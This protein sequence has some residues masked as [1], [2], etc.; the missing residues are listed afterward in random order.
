MRTG[1]S[2]LPP[3]EA[4]EGD[5]LIVKVPITDREY[6]LL[7]YRLQDPD[8]TFTYSFADLNGNRVPDFYDADSDSLD[9]QPTSSYDPLTDTWE[10]TEDS[11]WDYFMSEFPVTEADG[12]ARGP[13]RGNG[14][15][16]WHIDERVIRDALDA[17]TS[18][19]NA[20]PLRKG[21]DLEEADGI[22]DLDS[23]TASR[24]LLGWDRDCFRGEGVMIGEV[25]YGTRF[26]ADTLPDS[27]SADG[28]VTGFSISEIDSVQ[29]GAEGCEIG[30]DCPLGGRFLY[31]QRLG[32]TLGFADSTLPP[33]ISLK[34]RRTLP[35]DGPLGDV[36]LADLDGDGSAEIVMAAAGGALL[37]YRGDLSPWKAQ[38]D[39]VTVGLFARARGSVEQPE[40]QPRWLGAPVVGDLDGDG[41]P[42][43][44]LSAAEGIY[45]FDLSGAEL[46]DGDGDSSS[47]GLFLP[48]PQMGGAAGVISHPALF[49][50]HDGNLEGAVSTDRV[51]LVMIYRATDEDSSVRARRYEWDGDS[52]PVYHESSDTSDGSA[53][54]GILGWGMQGSLVLYVGGPLGGDGQGI[55]LDTLLGK[56][57]PAAVARS[58]DFETP[59]VFRPVFP[60]PS[61]LVGYRARPDASE[62]W[63][64]VDTL[65]FPT[66]EAGFEANRGQR[67][68]EPWSALAAGPMNEGGEPLFA[69]GGGDALWLLDRNMAQLR[70]GPYRP[71]YEGA[72]VSGG[73]PVSPLLV[74]LDGDGVVEVLWPD[75]VGRIHAVDL[76]SAP[77]EGWPILGPGEPTGS[78]AC[79]DIDGDGFLEFVAVAGFD[80]LVGMDEQE[81]LPVLWRKGEIR[82]Y[83]LAAP[84]TAFAPWSQGQADAWATGRQPVDSRSAGSAAGGELLEE[85]S[86]FV[87]PNPVDT[88]A[89]R[90]RAGVHRA[91]LVSAAIY[92]LQGQLLAR[93]GPIQAGGAGQIEF[94][95]NVEDL[96]SGLYLARVEAEDT[97]LVRAFA[98]VK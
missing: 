23:F 94:E 54:R 41:Q 82:V 50:P 53:R 8:G 55:R 52:E 22:Q 35:A 33:G 21:V 60:S 32:F 63:A 42:E 9:G 64:M 46:R 16:V 19:I 27:R 80:A 89:V 14:L 97:V 93:S 2:W 79:A 38:P 84:A 75:R 73:V 59:P 13:G 95:F 90:L 11:E 10:S 28:A 39:S 34:A 47:F 70:G 87:Y 3:V 25:L 5:T 26:T 12:P 96:V 4:G 83:G 18:T 81:R 48:A 49:A 77:L 31:R 58:Q 57:Q 37:A 71:A 40:R 24:F 44:F 6:W 86:L 7:E 68:E 78:P 15:Y 30:P 61:V 85:N 92:D 17:N 62:N 88:P 98:V 45:A 51:D 74:D 69:L 66:I 36:R 43:F 76:T 65:G 91:G 72:K 1:P 67:L 20:D 29:I 56:R